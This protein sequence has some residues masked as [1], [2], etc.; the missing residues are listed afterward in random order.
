MYGTKHRLPILFDISHPTG[1]VLP[2]T[3]D[4]KEFIS[5]FGANNSV[6]G[7]WRILGGGEAEEGDEEMK[8]EEDEDEHTMKRTKIDVD[9]LLAI[10]FDLK[11]KND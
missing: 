5:R 6:L 4:A 1:Y 11:K 10:C 9:S 7:V 3:D 2:T 8:E